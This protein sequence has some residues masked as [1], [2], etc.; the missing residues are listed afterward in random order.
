MIQKVRGIVLH[1][2]SYG[3]TSIIVQFYTHLYGRTAVMIKGAR[4][5]RKNR[6]ISLF[7]PLAL[8]DLEMDYKENRDLQ[9]IREAR[10]IV[11]LHGLMSDPVKS[12][13]AL[14]LSEVLYRTIRENEANPN[15]FD[16]LENSIQYFDLMKEGA[17]LFHLHMLVHLTRFLGFRP[18]APDKTGAYWFDMETGTFSEVRS[19]KENHLEPL[20]A[21]VLITLLQSTPDQLAEMKIPK[22]IRNQLIEKLLTYYSLHLQG[23]GTIKS[24]SVLKAVF[25]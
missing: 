22:N 4:G 23:M 6:R 15:L 1:H 5:Q 9:Q 13:I 16:Y 10:P 8:L 24:H 18:K 2:L 14:F 19:I 20:L 17:S 7:H 11:P 12:T 25:E 3:D 21:E